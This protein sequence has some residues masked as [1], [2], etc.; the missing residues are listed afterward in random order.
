MNTVNLCQDIKIISAIFHYRDNKRQTPYIVA[1]DKETRAVF[2]KY[3]AEN[4]DKYDYSKA[5]V[6]LQPYLWHVSL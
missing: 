2:R 1:P 5:Q 3:M 4:P 6:R